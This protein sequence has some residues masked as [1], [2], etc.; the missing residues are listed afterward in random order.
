MIQID[1]DRLR[2]GIDAR[3]RTGS[4]GGVQQFTAGL[5]A[6]LGRLPAGS[7]DYLA[8]SY[9]DDRGWLLPA[10]GHTVRALDAP[11]PRVRQGLI[12]SARRAVLRR[13]PFL[14]RIRSSLPRRIDTSVP[15]SDGTIERA[16]VDVMHFV[17]QSAFLTELPSI[18]HPW[19]LQHLHLPEFFTTEQVRQRDATYRA[20]CDAAE[21]I[22]AASSWTKADLIQKL[23]I[24]EEKIVV[25]P[26][27]HDVEVAPPPTAADLAAARAAFNLPERFLLYP[28]QTWPHKNHI[29]L[30]TAIAN[31]R[32]TSGASLELVLSGY[33]NEHFP[34]IRSA[35]RRLRLSDQVHFVGFVTPLQLQALYRLAVGLIFPSLFEGW[36]I[37]IVEAFRAGTPVACSNVTSLPSMVGDAAIVFDPYDVESIASAASTLW[38]DEAER[39]Q[40]TERGH[41]RARLFDPEPIA[42]TYRA[43]YRLVAGRPMSLADQLALSAPPVV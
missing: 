28:A 39:R 6:S 17:R 33:Q 11:L 16:G 35:V 42:A 26:V 14:R 5:V 10:L 20:F 23:D 27:A 18:Y 9:A 43:L 32:D 30:V 3:S 13:A 41:V 19:D 25:I 1:E 22:V 4:T 15:R 29:R 12:G 7:E 21:R 40:L 31:L 8:L 38:S 36:G 37:P 24:A 34:E 2:V